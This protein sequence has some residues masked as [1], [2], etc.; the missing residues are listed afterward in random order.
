MLR[1]TWDYWDHLDAFQAFLEG[2]RTEDES[3]FFNSAHTALANLN[4]IYLQELQ[5]G[6]VP[7]VPTEFVERGGEV[8]AIEHAKS[9][10][11][12]SIVVKPA[13]GAAASGL[14]KFEAPNADALAY[15][16]QL[17][18]GDRLA[19]VQPFMPRVTTEGETS[20]VYFN[21]AFSHAVTKMPATGDFRSQVDFGGVYTLVDPTEAQRAVAERTL[22]AWEDRYNDA[23]L[24]ARVDLVPGDSGEPLLGELELIEPEL[25]LDMHEDAAATFANAILARVE[26][27]SPP[28]DGRTD[29]LGGKLVALTLVVLFVVVLLAGVGTIVRWILTAIFGGP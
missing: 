11:W 20:L 14:K 27:H 2:C 22:A 28:A 24:Y 8:A 26:G 15:L 10:G 1:T 19:L 25:F 5:I 7:I 9:S 12:S 4:K 3:A 13:V 23:P 29:S 17:T 21:G 6:G 18:R 16:A